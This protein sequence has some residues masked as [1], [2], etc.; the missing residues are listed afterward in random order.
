MPEETLF[1]LP[2][3][4]SPVPRAPTRPENARVLRPIRNQ[5]EW[6]PRSLDDTLPGDHQAR[7]IWSVLEKL[8]LSAFYGSIKAVL[9]GPGRSTT[10]PQVLLAV[11]LF[12]TTDGIGSA[13]QLARLCEEHDA[14][15]WL[16]G[17]VPTNYHMLSDF[18][19]AHKKELDELMTKILAGMMS[20]GLVALE[21]VAQ[22]GMR[23][24]ASAGTNS[25]R[26]KERLGACLVEAK[27]QVERL[28]KEREHPDPEVNKRQEAARKRVAKEREQR[29][30]EALRNMPELEASKERQLK[31]KSKKDRAKVKE[32]RVSTTDPEARVMKM[33]DGGFQP[34]YNFQFASEVGTQV[35]VGVGVTTQGN[36]KGQAVPM[37][38]QIDERTDEKPDDY[39]MDGSYVTREDITALEKQAITVYAPTLAPRTETSGRTQSTP[40]EDD[41]KE[42]ADW[43]TRMETE[44][45]KK[46]YRQRAATA[47]C[48]NARGR[49]FGLRQLTVRGTAKVLSV[50]LIVAIT[51]NILRW[52]ALTS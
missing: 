13:R 42:V 37:V 39:L 33:P 48:V 21:R 43:R 4:Q 47:E 27:E 16:C 24:R 5:I 10:D 49:A 12:A 8:N 14:Y 41:T 46:I 6:M 34:A 15:R 22:D 23:V 29:I 52:I 51:H 40:R 36:D 7:A 2:E 44:E 11:W 30:E 45:A 17:G 18:R 25:F 35:I 3:K 9:D 20:E 19:V 28:A 32:P 31:K 1:D 26:R 38:E 50:A